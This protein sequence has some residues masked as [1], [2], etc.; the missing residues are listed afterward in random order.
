MVFTNENSG[1]KPCVLIHCQYVYGIG[2][3]VR[4]VELARSI[5]MSFNVI[6]LNGGEPVPNYCIPPDVSCV[7]L[8]A[9][10]KLEHADGLVPVDKSQSLEAC[11]AAR[12]SIIESVL[13]QI[14]PAILITEHFP[15]GLLFEAEA[16]AMIAKIK[17]LNRNAK[18]VCSVRDIV[19]SSNGGKQDNQTCDLLNHWFDMVL[20]HGDEK[21]IPFFASFPMVGKI[22]IPVINTGYIVKEI[23]ATK[24]SSERPT[25]LVSIGGGRL[26]QELLYA[27]IHAQD[28]VTRHWPHRLIIFTGAFQDNIQQLHD[29]A[30]LN[31]SNDITIK[32]FDE[33]EYRETLP[34][35]SGI[36][37]LGGYNTLVEAV[38]A[39][40]PILVYSRKFHGSNEEQALRLKFFELNG[41]IRVISPDDL[42]SKLLSA[43]ILEFRDY[44]KKSSTHVRF[45]GTENTRRILEQVLHDQINEAQPLESIGFSN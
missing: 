18:I 6:I 42:S 31:L 40:L 36:I 33:K 4:T 12:L 5:S 26:G 13:N 38:S 19:E 39:Q 35:V 10:Y 45:D 25:I 17:Q 20:V 16:I 30:K 21:V 14:T 34:T 24:S 44:R 7:Q 3:F 23:I 1:V 2:H 28:I 43:K 22:K 8:P 15:F 41:L 32:C 29:L 11:F 27:V 37:C 9:I